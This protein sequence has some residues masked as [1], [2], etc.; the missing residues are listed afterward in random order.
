MLPLAPLR[1]TPA[2]PEAPSRQAACL[3][4]P[5]LSISLESQPGGRRVCTPALLCLGTRP[6]AFWLHS[7][8]AAWACSSFCSFPDWIP[9]SPSPSFSSG[10]QLLITL[11]RLPSFPPPPL[12]PPPYLRSILSYP[13]LCP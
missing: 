6:T 4:L 5:P 13:F 2:R 11:L 9:S 3:R 10:S 7:F 8:L 12:P 1:A